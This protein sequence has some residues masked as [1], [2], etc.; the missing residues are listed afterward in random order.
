MIYVTGDTHGEYDRLLQIDKALSEDDYI[1]VC[2]D[3][4]YIF[5]N[6]YNEKMLLDDLEA[7]P[8]TILFVDGNHENFPAIYEYQ[9]EVWHGGKVHRIRKNILHLCRGQVYKIGGSTFFTMGGANSSDKHM[10]RKGVSWWEEEMTTDADYVEANKNLDLCGRKVDYIITHTLPYKT[11]RMH[12]LDHGE[13]E[14]PLN[15]FLEYIA[16]SVEYKHW[17]CGHFH[18]DKD[19]GRNIRICWYDVLKV[20][21]N[22]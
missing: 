17:Y 21:S 12:Y 1:I 10:R 14:L 2:G 5:F 15:N 20:G 11:L 6:D 18:M 13:E 9:E 19:L 16:E 4:G 8:Y 22:K 7:R 3:F